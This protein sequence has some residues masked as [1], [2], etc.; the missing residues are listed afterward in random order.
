MKDL[1]RLVA[2]AAETGHTLDPYARHR[3]LQTVRGPHD[4]GRLISLQ[5]GPVVWFRCHIRLIEEVQQLWPF[6]GKKT[7]FYCWYNLAMTRI[8]KFLSAFKSNEIFRKITLSKL[9][10]I[11]GNM[12]KKND[13]QKLAE[14]H[15]NL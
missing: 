14:D 15:V 13:G 11:L 5:G 3:T 10:N 1:E 8:D 9:V 7:T 2:H 12:E 6:L 4:L